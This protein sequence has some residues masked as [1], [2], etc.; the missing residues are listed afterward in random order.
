MNTRVS[1]MNEQSPLYEHMI[2]YINEQSPLFE[3]Q[4]LLY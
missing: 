4:G 3:L 1:Y 2:S